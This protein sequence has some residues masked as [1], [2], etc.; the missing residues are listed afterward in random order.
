MIQEPHNNTTE[1]PATI[2]ELVDDMEQ[3]PDRYQHLQFILNREKH[4]NLGLGQKYLVVNRVGFGLYE[5]I[6]VDYNNGIISL[7]FIIPDTGNQ[8]EIC[9]DVN[10]KHPELFLINWKDIQDMVCDERTFDYVD[11]VLLERNDE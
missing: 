11:D 2:Q 8:A 4:H 10:N 1:Y 3:H 6:S 5:L 7:I 9:L